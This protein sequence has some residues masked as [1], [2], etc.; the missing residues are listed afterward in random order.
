MTNLFSGA[1][2][3]R[4]RIL[5][6]GGLASGDLP[7]ADLAVGVASEQG[8]AVGGPGERD[9]RGRESLGLGVGHGELELELIHDA[10]ALEVPDADAIVGGS[11]QPVAVGGEAQ[12]VD[13]VTLLATKRVQALA[14][15]EVPEHGNTVL[16]ARGAQGTIR[17]HGDSVDVAR[18]TDEVGAE[19]AVG[20]LPNLD[21][22]VPATGH[23]QR[24]LRV[25][26][27]GH[28]GH[29]LGV[30]LALGLDGVLA[31]AQGVP[32]LDGLVAGARHDLTV[33]S[34]EGDREDILVVADEAAGGETSVEVPQTE[35]AV[36]GAG[37]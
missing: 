27:E 3:A 34:A 17:G 16:A 1:T 12:G 21:E 15:V 28:A 29:P 9:A 19:L 30:T 32:Q 20:Q 8:V 26:G 14:L 36:P 24:V 11:A 31:L 10:L 33:V 2:Q 7:H 23:D 22:F 18:V 25:G 6:D 35:G 37:Q 5:V 13:D 4:T